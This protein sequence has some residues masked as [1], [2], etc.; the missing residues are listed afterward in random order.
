MSFKPNQYIKAKTVREVTALLHQYGEEAA[1]VAG[2][3]RLHESAVRGMIP[4]VKKLIDIE[5]LGLNYIE[6]GKEGIKIGASTNL[7][8]IR[9]YPLFKRG[10]AY[11]ALS[12]AASI[13]PIQILELGTIGGNICAGL[14]FLNFP[15]VVSALDAV[16]K[17]VSSEGERSI[18]AEE[19][20][21][22]YFVTALKPNEFI[23]EI[24]IPTLPER[25][26]S[27]F[28]AF[29]ILTVGFPAISI[30]T[31]VTLSGN[32]ICEDIRIVFGSA[33][34]IPIK[35]INAERKL[36]GKKLD[37]KAI[38]EVAEAIPEEIGYIGDLRASAEYKK[39][40]STALTENALIKAR[41]RAVS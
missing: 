29:K 8:N 25:T 40:L 31:R 28:Q 18:P 9:D 10:G 38:K 21:I 15:P 2:G 17:V 41:E 27:V 4:K 22:D 7:R 30:A 24:R 1:I 39:E 19:F 12:E 5:Q 23:T 35:A 33:G 3:T 16:L 36:T 26:G 11:T 34:R 32:G 37:D 20:F 13:L 6:S 14:P